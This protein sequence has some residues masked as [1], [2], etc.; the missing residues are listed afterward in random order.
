MPKPPE[1]FKVGGFDDE[2]MEPTEPVRV[3]CTDC[4]EVSPW[5]TFRDDGGLDTT[6]ALDVL[7]NWAREHRCIHPMGG[8]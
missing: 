1:R 4:G 2:S 6:A 8:A 5:F 7:I 3:T